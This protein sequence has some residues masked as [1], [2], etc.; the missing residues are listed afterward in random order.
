[1]TQVQIKIITLFV[2]GLLLGPT[3]HLY[4][5]LFSG[6]SLITNTLNEISDRW[7]LDDHSIFRIS[8]GMSY[9]P[10]EMPLTP[11]E[12]NVIIEIACKP[13]PCDQIDEMT[14]SLSSGS[15]VAFREVL[16]INSFLPFNDFTTGAISIG[17]PEKYMILVEPKLTTSNPPS[18]VLRV[19]KNTASPSIILLAIGY[20]FCLL[21]CLFLLRIFRTEQ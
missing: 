7:V 6:Q 2:V 17:Y 10:L 19:K 4:C 11:N 1:M 20:G 9:Q 14:L 3:Y 12:N 15:N 13:N 16:E 8:S 18:I 5:S 21:P